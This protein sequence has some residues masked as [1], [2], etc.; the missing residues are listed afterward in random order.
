MS[1]AQRL[2]IAL[3]VSIMHDLCA[4]DFQTS[5]AAVRFF[6]CFS[7]HPVSTERCRVTQGLGKAQ[8]A[9]G[10]NLN[11]TCRLCSWCQTDHET[12]LVLGDSDGITS[13]SGLGAVHLG[14]R[15]LGKRQWTYCRDFY[16]SGVN[17]VSAS[18]DLFI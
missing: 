1:Q 8:L 14:S 7:C 11:R 6:F 4:S 3:H 5:D 13:P 9:N 10:R 17:F 16:S 18:E 12:S 2:W 15:R